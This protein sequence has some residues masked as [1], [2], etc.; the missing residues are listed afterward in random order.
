MGQRAAGAGDRP[1]RSGRL[2]GRRPGHR[3]RRHRLP[4][5]GHDRRAEPGAHD[6]L[7]GPPPPGDGR[8]AS[9]RGALRG[10]RRRRPT[11][12][13]GT[14]TS[15]ARRCTSPTAGRRCSATTTRS[16]PSGPTR[17]STSST[18]TTCE[19]L[20]REI[21]HHLAGESPHFEN[22]HRIR[23][24]DGGWRWVLTRGLTTRDAEGRPRR[25]TGSL[26]DITD[27]RVAQER[28]IHD[29]LHDSLTGLPNRALFMDR[30]T[31]C[32]RHLRAR[33]G[34]RCAAALRR[35]RPLQARQRQ[36]QPRGRRPAADRDR[37]PRRPRP[38]PGRHAGAP[39][40]RRVRDPARRRDHARLR[41][42]DRRA[43]WPAR[44]P[45]R[46]ASTAASCRSRRAS[47]SPTTSTAA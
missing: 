33:P 6:P 2:R 23:H 46:S 45:S 36:P 39:G 17:G 12:G 30:L 37:P 10:R 44:S 4:R 40:R 25:I 15:P 42:G 18:P 24:A 16:P 35:H 21:D 19:R 43:R 29:A 32:L 38:A 7:R 13:S 34:L 31:Q 11:T 5:Q 22:E 28:L 1:H 8:P 20:R 14:G 26:S 41:A 47:A 27:R 3:A 9:Q